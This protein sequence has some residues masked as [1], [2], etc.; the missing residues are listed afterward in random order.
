MGRPHPDATEFDTQ[1]G[2]AACREAPALAL[3]PAARTGPK[4][5][6][7]SATALMRAPRCAT[8]GIRPSTTKGPPKPA[9]VSALPGV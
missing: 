9:P 4:P 3:V 2:G 5:V 6:S 7:S 8:P 1:V